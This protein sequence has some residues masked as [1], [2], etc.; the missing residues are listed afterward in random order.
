MTNEDKKSV[1]VPNP[2]CLEICGLKFAIERV[3]SDD[4]DEDSEETSQP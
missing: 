2:S 4:D 3:D 1:E